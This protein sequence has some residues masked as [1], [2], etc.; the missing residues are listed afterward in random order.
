MLT[1]RKC[2]IQGE[3]TLEK[4]HVIRIFALLVWTNL[5]VF[6]LNS[7]SSTYL[8]IGQSTLN[9]RITKD[10]SEELNI[11]LEILEIF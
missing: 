7:K 10:E 4:S 5:N 6:Q 1:K 9:T 11:I 8:L 3:T 2:I